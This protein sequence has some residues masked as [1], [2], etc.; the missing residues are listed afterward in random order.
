[1][2]ICVSLARPYSAEPNLIE[3]SHV[4]TQ[5]DNRDG[6]VWANVCMLLGSHFGILFNLN[7]LVPAEGESTEGKVG[8]SWNKEFDGSTQSYHDKMVIW[9]V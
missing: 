2:W 6:N 3:D 4:S 7:L 1:M 9:C 5:S 8:P